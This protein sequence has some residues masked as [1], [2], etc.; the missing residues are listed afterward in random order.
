[1]KKTSLPFKIVLSLLVA[2]AL[3]VALTAFAATSIQQCQGE[4]GAAL[5]G[6]CNEVRMSCMK[7]CNGSAGC[8]NYCQNNVFPKCMDQGAQ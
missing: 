7:S 4:E 2:A 8:Q 1:M 3:A 5:G 6:C